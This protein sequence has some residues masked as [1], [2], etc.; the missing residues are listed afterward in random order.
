MLVKAVRVLV[1]AVRE[2]IK[3]VRPLARPDESLVEA[4]RCPGRL[5][6]CVKAWRALA[7]ALGMPKEAVKVPVEA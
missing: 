2:L 1:M 5:K 4:V 6:G 7:E 3:A